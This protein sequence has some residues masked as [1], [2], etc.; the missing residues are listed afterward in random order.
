MALSFWQVKFFKSKTFISRNLHVYDNW[1]C[2]GPN[3]SNTMYNS[4]SVI[5]GG[6][7]HLADETKNIVCLAESKWQFS[8]HK[9]VSS[10]PRPVW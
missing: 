9:V 3:M 2:G 6:S 4:I 10:T 5:S 8:S 1:L 7:F